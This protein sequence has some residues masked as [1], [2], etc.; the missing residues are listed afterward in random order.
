MIFVKSLNGARWLRVLIVVTGI[1][2]AANVP[3]ADFPPGLGVQ[4][5]AVGTGDLAVKHAQVSVH[6]TG[7]LTDGTKFDSSHDRGKVFEFT[8]G[9]GQVI[10]GWD[11]GVAGMRV[12][13]KRTLSIA[14]HL[15]Y[16]ERGAGEVIPPNAPLRFE[17]ELLAVVA[18]GYE[19]I[20]NETL[21]ARVD[22]GVKI[23]DIR[24][25]EEWRETGVVAGSILIT[26]FDKSGRLV[27]SF[28]EALSKAVDKDE[29]F[30]LICRTGNRTSMLAQ[31]LVA[32]AG[33]KQVANA[34]DGI[35]EWIR[36]GRPVE[37]KP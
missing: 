18:P 2:A 1:F 15:G 25:D 14:P 6:Y 33:Y 36:E 28:P 9:M 20:S 24:R 7:W 30:I 26:A 12:G 10:P 34:T 35:T 29:A 21:K 19:N 22:A 23:L 5:D 32:Q 37:A 13:G 16:G 3:A 17:V 4:D 31:A 8:L 27:R 11:L